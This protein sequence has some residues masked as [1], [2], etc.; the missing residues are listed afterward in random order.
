MPKPP[1]TKKLVRPSVKDVLLAGVH[2][3]TCYNNFIGNRRFR[4]LVDM[5]IQEYVECGCRN[6]RSYMI[7]NVVDLAL[8]SGYRFL[9][10]DEW[11]I[12][13]PIPLS[14]MRKK[15]NATCQIRSS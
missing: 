12:F 3:K 7:K 8:K 5:F 14:D 10:Q 15:V 9:S 1:S 6:Q 13:T 2:G 4:K 11:G